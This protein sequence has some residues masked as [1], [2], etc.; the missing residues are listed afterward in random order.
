MKPLKPNSYAVHI[1]GIGFKNTL[2]TLKEQK[3]IIR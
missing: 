2:K 3:Y 1:D